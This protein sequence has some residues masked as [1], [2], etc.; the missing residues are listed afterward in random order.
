M[1]SMTEYG[2]S[3][4]NRDEKHERVSSMDFVNKII[5]FQRTDLRARDF[6]MQPGRDERYPI[7]K[8]IGDRDRNRET[9]VA[10]DYYVTRF[11]NWIFYRLPDIYLMK[12]EALVESGGDLAEAL[13]CVSQSYDRA[14]PDL[15]EGSLEIRSVEAMRA[16]V[17]EE[18]Q[19]EFLFE[20]KRYFDLLRRM[21]RENSTANI[22][23]FLMRKYPD[24][25]TTAKS[26]L[27][28][29]DALYMPV[30]ENEL[31]TNPLLKQNPF[32][33][34]SSDITKK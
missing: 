33:I 24:N 14:N 22:V 27:S 2:G 1:Y 19:R 32:Y 12:A 20:G 25:Q 5:L 23:D 21:K 13:R 7:M 30:N 15:D 18:R 4:T 10:N 26:K 6:Y 3:N 17:F 16:L 8:Y 9:P 29:P 11:H 31:K 34:L 28:D